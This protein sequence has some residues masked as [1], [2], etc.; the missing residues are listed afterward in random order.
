MRIA[1]I[2]EVFP[3]LS[4]SGAVQLRDLAKE[5]AAQGHSVTVLVASPELTTNWQIETLF[6]VAVVRLKTPKTRDLS[7]LRRIVGEFLMPFFMLRNLSLSPLRNQVWDGVVWYSPTIFLG[8]IVSR[9]RHKSNCKSYLIIRD[10]FPE[11]AVDIGLMR[12][13]IPFYLLRLVA[14]YQYSVADVIGIQARGNA[15]YFEKRIASGGRLEVLQNWLA[16]GC[17]VGC[18]IRLEE[19]Q[20]AGRKIFVYAGNMGVAQGVNTMIELAQQL[21]SHKSIGFAFVGRGSEVQKLK[22]LVKNMALDNVVFFDE[23]APEEIPGLYAQC[24][25][26]LVALDVRHKSHNIPGKFLSYM[27]SG[28]PVLAC[29]NTGNDLIGMIEDENV[30][31]VCSDTG[32]LSKLALELL[33]KIE[34][35]TGYAARCKSLSAR[36]FSPSAAVNQIVAALNG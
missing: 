11:W 1:L 36:L 7:Y 22:D 28:L 15:V 32:Q 29:I 24:E 2:V 4:S 18:R 5:F 34:M 26:G 3:P 8:P 10:I 19:T 27:Q 30:G 20:L 13:G 9:L 14:R 17:N 16:D 6:G 21:V 25:V 23:I 33:H 12:R 35:D 31:T